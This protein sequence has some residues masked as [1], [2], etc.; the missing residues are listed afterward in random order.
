MMSSSSPVD[1][2]GFV[3]ETTKRKVRPSRASIGFTAAL[4][5]LSVY[6]SILV[7]GETALFLTFP[8]AAVVLPLITF[9]RVRPLKMGLPEPVGKGLESEI[10][11]RKALGQGVL[12]LILGMAM[13]FVPIALLFYLPG[14]LVLGVVLGVV[15]G[16]SLSDSTF[17]VW[18]A[19]IE[20]RT[21]S[22]IF[23]VTELV[24]E[25]GRQLLVKSVEMLPRSDDSE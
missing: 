19:R 5:V 16:L 24:E 25:D 1:E 9:L 20:K 23:S 7:L 6:V 17:S 18:I 13:L 14:A 22:E 21:N 8:L 10:R 12:L 3:H 4:S 11:S 2:T 15:T